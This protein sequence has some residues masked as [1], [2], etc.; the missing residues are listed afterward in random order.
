MWRSMFAK[1][2]DKN[3]KELNILISICMP[4]SIKLSCESLIN[5]SLLGYGIRSIPLFFKTGNFE[6]TNALFS[7]IEIFHWNSALNG[8]EK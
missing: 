7:F 3:F 2:N 1:D 5:I 8:C 4:K 6:I